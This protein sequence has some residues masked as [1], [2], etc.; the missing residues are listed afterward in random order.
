MAQTEIYSFGIGGDFC[1]NTENLLSAQFFQGL[2]SGRG[3][4]VSA[5]LSLRNA[6]CSHSHSDTA[7]SCPVRPQSEPLALEQLYW[8]RPGLRGWIKPGLTLSYCLPTHV[9]SL[10]QEGSVQ[11]GLCVSCT[12]GRHWRVTGRVNRMWG[13]RETGSTTALLSCYLS[14]LGWDPIRG[15]RKFKN[16]FTNVLNLTNHSLVYKKK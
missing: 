10:A 13:H 14:C 15:Q 4:A 6:T 11:S 7:G 12:G 16:P 5:A 2:V 3:S 8:S 9:Q 1:E